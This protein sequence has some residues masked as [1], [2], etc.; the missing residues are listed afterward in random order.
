M[1]QRIILFTISFFLIIPTQIIVLSTNIKLTIIIIIFLFIISIFRLI[2]FNKISKRI[3]YILAYFTILLFYFIL[4][5]LFYGLSDLYFFEKVLF[6]VIMFFAIYEIIIYY[7]LLYQEKYIDVILDTIVIIGFLH[8]IIMILAL[9]NSE[10]R[11]WLYNYIAISE[12]AQIHFSHNIRSTGLFYSGFA[13]LSFFNAIILVIA[14][15]KLKDRTFLQSILKAVIILT[16]FIAITISGRTGFIILIFG[17]FYLYIF[18]LIYKLEYKNSNFKTFFII[19]IILL[20]LI[21]F[22]I[23]IKKVEHNLAWAFE[24]IFNFI[25]SSSFASKSTTHLFSE[26]YF[27]PANELQNIIGDSNFGRSESLPYIDSDSGYVLFIH[28]GGI[29]GIIIGYSI[30]IYFLIISFKYT[31]NNNLKFLSSFL[32]IALIIGN[33]KDVYYFSF[34]GY[35]QILFILILL[36]LTEKSF[37]IN[38]RNRKQLEKN[39]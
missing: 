14:L 15:V 16:L 25:E 12:H 1:I 39:I 10:F 28:G 8:A 11:E 33:I 4:N 17:M 26:M 6:A 37:Y 24:F 3:I 32:I 27:L 31:H 21:F 5:S 13:T 35:T 22:V 7:K 23:D 18:N 9:F 36:I 29:M 2:Y 38:F 19:I 30:Y 20:I 34:S